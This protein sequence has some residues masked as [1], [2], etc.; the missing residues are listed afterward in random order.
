MISRVIAPI[1]KNNYRQ[2]KIILFYERD[3]DFFQPFIK[4]LRIH[5]TMTAPTD[6]HDQRTQWII[7][8]E[9][10]SNRNMVIGSI[11]S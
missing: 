1:H 4:H 7:C 6:E 10:I 11:S 8:A 3:E 2:L 5:K 9:I